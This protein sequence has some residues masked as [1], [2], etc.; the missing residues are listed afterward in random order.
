MYIQND[1]ISPG[2]SNKNRCYVWNRLKENQSDDLGAALENE[3]L[4]SEYNVENDFYAGLDKKKK[5]QMDDPNNSM[6]VLKKEQVSKDLALL[7]L[8][9]K[10]VIWFLQTGPKG[11]VEFF[12]DHKKRNYDKNNLKVKIK[13]LKIYFETL[14]A[15]VAED[16]VDGKFIENVFYIC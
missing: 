1:S 12:E 10:D 2:I 11:T 15:L 13:S 5:T 14:Y 16:C 8:I 3:S 6:V 7:R 4:D 9:K